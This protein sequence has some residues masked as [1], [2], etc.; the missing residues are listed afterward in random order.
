MVLMNMFDLF[1]CDNDG[2]LSREEFNIYNLRTGEQGTSDEEWQVLT[3][4]R[5]RACAHYTRMQKHLTHAMVHS[6]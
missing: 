5:R 6:P 2:Q 3:G 4:T 1:D